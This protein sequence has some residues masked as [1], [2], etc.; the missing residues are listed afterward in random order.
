MNTNLFQ[1]TSYGNYLRRLG[2]TETFLRLL[3]G[4][5]LAIFLYKT[6]FFLPA[7]VVK[8]C[9]ILADKTMTPQMH[10]P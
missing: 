10:V 4:T 3:T 2:D 6:H 7:R 5:A 8:I 9:E 1:H